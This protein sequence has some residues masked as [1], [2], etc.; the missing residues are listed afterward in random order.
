MVPLTVFGNIA[1]CEELAPLKDW[2]KFAGMISRKYGK[3]SKVSII[4]TLKASI[5]GVVM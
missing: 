2:M 5:V 1:L 3:S 4:G